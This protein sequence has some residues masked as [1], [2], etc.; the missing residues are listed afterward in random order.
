MQVEKYRPRGLDDVVGNQETVKILKE[1]V[2][3]GNLPHLLLAV[4]VDSR[5]GNTPAEYGIA[6]DLCCGV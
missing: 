1:I 6:C 4:S 5:R 2:D 3:H